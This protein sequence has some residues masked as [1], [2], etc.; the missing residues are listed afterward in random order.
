MPTVVSTSMV[1]LTDL[2]DSKSLNLYIEYSQR[3]QQ[4]YDP[5]TGIYNPDYTTNKPVL[6][7]Q[8][9]VAGGGGTNLAA[10]AKSIKWYVD[11]VLLSASTADYTL[12]SS[13]VKTLTINTNILASV[14]SKL[15]TVEAVWT[16]PD[17]GVDVSAK[18]DVEFVKLTNGAS[19]AA[20]VL[21][22]LS[23]ESATISTLSDGSG[24]VY[25][26]AVT[27]LSIFEGS[28]D[29]TASY[30]IV[31]TRTGATVTEA[32]SSRTATVTAMSTDTATV[33][34]TATRSGYPTLTKTFNLAKNKQGVAGTTPTSY[35]LVADVSAIQKNISNVYNPTSINVSA[36]S[37]TG[38]ATPG[39]YQARFIISDSTDGTTFTTRYTS[40]ANEA[41]KNYVPSAGIKALKVQMFAAGGTTTL[42]DEQVIP[43]V[44]DG[45]TGADAVLVTVTTPNGNIIKNS[46]GTLTAQCDVYKGTGIQTATSYKWY[47]QDPTATTS[48]GGDA[49]GGAGWRLINATFNLGV[50]GYTS[51]TITIP[52]QAIPNTESFKCVAT[53]GGVKYSDVCTVTDITDPISSTIIGGDKFKNGEGTVTLKAIVYQNGAE[54]DAAGTLYT[55]TWSLYDMSNNK[56]TTW[57]GT[58]SK[59]GKTITVAAADVTGQANIGVD[60]SK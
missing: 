54:V 32:A 6:T 9:T 57:N 50:T 22:S 49:D 1:T 24:G 36:K 45:A 7:P 16:D 38:T 10:S 60:I 15:F 13:G 56:I 4:I 26:G 40:A 58:G 3:R 37:Q 41:A 28:T 17:T 29:V 11:G 18:N 25:T 34:F 55:Y 21:A 20:A 59:T 19:G 8:L 43:V 39:A 31:Q 30:T 35:W 33:L 23:N 53:Y 47:L 14:S 42:L 46:T 27:T 2:N 44:S 48:S 51:A 12:A 52:A 5:N